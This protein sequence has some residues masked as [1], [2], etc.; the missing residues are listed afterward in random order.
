MNLSGFLLKWVIVKVMVFN[1]DNQIKKNHNSKNFTYSEKLRDQ[2]WS[3]KRD[4]VKDKA[5]YMCQDCGSEKSLEVHHCYYKYG[6]EPWQYPIDSLKCFCSNC[7]EGNRDGV[8]SK[9]GRPD[10]SRFKTDV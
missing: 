5:N 6:L 7:H 10:H 4:T 9:N 1:L 2:R 8:K 3:D